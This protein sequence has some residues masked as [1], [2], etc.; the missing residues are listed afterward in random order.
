M[1][2]KTSYENKILNSTNILLKRS[3]LRPNKIISVPVVSVTCPKKVGSVGQ[4]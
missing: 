4:I 2:R 3:F 1:K